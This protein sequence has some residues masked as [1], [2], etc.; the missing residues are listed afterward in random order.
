MNIK[1]LRRERNKTK[2]KTTLTDKKN[3]ISSDQTFNRV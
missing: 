1:G 2:Y 3:P